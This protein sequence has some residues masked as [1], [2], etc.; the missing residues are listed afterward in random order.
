MQV[1]VV[2]QA[3]TVERR[4]QHLVAAAV[5]LEQTLAETGLAELQIQAAAEAADMVLLAHL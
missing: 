5:T 1:V 3:K 4:E 2:D